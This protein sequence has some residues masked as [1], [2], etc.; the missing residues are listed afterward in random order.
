MLSIPILASADSLWVSWRG[1]CS[2]IPSHISFVCKNGVRIVF[3]V[4]F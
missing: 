2:F 4:D 1:V 3:V